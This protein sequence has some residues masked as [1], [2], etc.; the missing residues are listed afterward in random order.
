MM[1]KS[2]EGS[3]QFAG[4]VPPG[5][6]ADLKGNG[7]SFGGSRQIMFFSPIKRETVLLSSLNAK[8]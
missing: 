4:L 3:A 2:V 1:V 8:T 6:R 7:S 5:K